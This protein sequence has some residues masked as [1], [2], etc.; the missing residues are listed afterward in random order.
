MTF[1][2]FLIVA[3]AALIVAAKLARLHQRYTDE[4]YSESRE[5]FILDAQAFAAKSR[6]IIGKR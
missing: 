2:F 3:G 5:E 4:Q 6:Q 1:E